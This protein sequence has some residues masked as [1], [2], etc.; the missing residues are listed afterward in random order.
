[1]IPFTPLPL[2]RLRRAREIFPNAFV[3][4]A[5]KRWQEATGKEATLA[6]SEESFNQVAMNREEVAQ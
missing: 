1:M 4:V 2:A 5:I 3:D 6:G